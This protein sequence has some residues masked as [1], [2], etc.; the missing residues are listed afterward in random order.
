MGDWLRLHRWQLGLSMLVFAGI[1]LGITALRSTPLEANPGMPEMQRIYWNWV[2]TIS[3][4]AEEAMESGLVLLNERPEIHQLYVRL[5]R[6]CVDAEA[7]A[8][9]EQAMSSLQ[10][11]DSLSQLYRD[12][13]LYHLQDPDNSD[14]TGVRWRALAR[15]PTL[16]PPVAR[17]IIDRGFQGETETWLT[18]VE[19]AWRQQLAQDS[20]AVGVAFGLG[21]AA[22]L[23][24][25]W[26]AAEALLDH[27]AK[28]SPDESDVYR[29]LGRMYYF[30]DQ[31]EKL[32]STL[33]RGVQAAETRH[34]LEQ[35]LIQRGNLGVM[36]TRQDRDLPKAEALFREALVQS[37]MLAD[38][39]TEGL[40][41]FRLAQLLR[42]QHRYDEAL[43]VLDTAEVI[44]A[45]HLPQRRASVLLQ[46]GEILSHIY[47]FSDA[48]AV[49][50]EAVIEADRWGRQGETV[51]SYARLA[52][53]RYSMGRYAAAREASLEA[54][55]L[56]QELD[57]KEHE[58]VVREILGE[59]ERRLGSFEMAAIHFEQGLAL[60][61][62]INNPE[63]YRALATLLGL[64]ALDLQ[65]ANTAK[66]HFEDLLA[67]FEED[68]LPVELARAYHGLGLT[69][70]QFGN[71]TE[72][73]RYYD[74]ALAQLTEASDPKF[75]YRVL[76][77]KA[78]V[79]VETQAFEQA[80]T[81]FEGARRIGESSLDG[82]ESRYQVEVGLGSVFMGQERYQ[83]A[84]DHFQNADAIEA[85]V[86]RPSVHWVALL[87]KPRPTGGSIN[88]S[89]PKWLSEKRST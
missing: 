24:Y 6:V 43:A 62:E 70:Q 60:A 5:A 53:L 39:E 22:V 10:P 75:H 47:R 21:Y 66:Q 69:Y 36:L 78:W 51:D 80:A 34:D 38:G 45:R 65:D 33:E 83:Q 57:L 25:E 56:A 87:R 11:P 3:Q 73:L 86:R 35:Q 26:D 2:G 31:W 52:Q 89:K 17:I 84:I 30:T 18:D 85:E 77:D 42:K 4:G 55:T 67:S 48:E 32:F 68:I 16:D 28:L 88:T 1:A 8:R 9:C 12:A 23:R 50:E 79:L 64:S 63:R 19:A 54:L 71:T 29:E 7:E 76:M 27:A 72:A 82:I 81:F 14:T 15:A 74:L 58:I 44:Y 37:R 49:L 20:S 61:R 59:A 41:L 46:R 40:N 13:A